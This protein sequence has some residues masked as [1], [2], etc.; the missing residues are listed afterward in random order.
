MDS[1]KTVK[2]IPIA[3]ILI[4]DRVREDFGPIK[5]L[6]SSIQ[7]SGLI[8]PIT[9][10]L[11]Q[12]GSATK[13]ELLAG[14]RR[15][16]AHLFLDRTEILANIYPYLTDVRDRKVI[17]LMENVARKDLTWQEKIK[18]EKD[19]HNIQ[20]EIH[21]KAIQ[22]PSAKG[23]GKSG[24]KTSDT[25]SL[26]G[27]SQAKISSDLELAS[28]L[29]AVPALKKAKTASEARC[30]LDKQVSGMLNSAIASRT[31]ATLQK[32]GK[33]KD[34]LIREAA[35]RYLIGDCTVELKKLPS[36]SYDF[37]EL[38]PPY[39]VPLYDMSLDQSQK[40]LLLSSD[41]AYKID[42]AIEI[43]RPVLEECARVLKDDRW[44]MVWCAFTTLH[45][46]QQACKELGFT[47]VSSPAFWVKTDKCSGTTPN[48][49]QTLPNVVE[50]F[51]YCRRGDISFME[52]SYRSDGNAFL[53]KRVPTGQKIH[54]TEKPIDLLQDIQSLFTLPGHHLLIPYAGSGNSMLAAYQTNRLATGIDIDPR[55]KGQFV[56]RLLQHH[57]EEV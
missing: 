38:D 14:E 40:D 37:I 48:P 32:E 29:E 30:L 50:K 36:N 15:V 44:M 2:T 51:F 8:N 54:P 43:I 3:D 39:G 45:A 13:Y 31:I 6:A 27:V 35:D 26:L 34:Q 1:Q 57:P 28:A 4:H 49:D 22:G 52:K 9:V 21:G 33:E 25:A 20:V 17:E 5:D 23:E 24:W 18:L 7:Q 56:Q 16:R 11:P 12:D 19:I 42:Q 47:V 10:M 41:S 53:Y 55:Y 46:I